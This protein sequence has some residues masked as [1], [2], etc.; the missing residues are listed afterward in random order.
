[1]R[2]SAST[3]ARRGRPPPCSTA[4]PSRRC[5]LGAAGCGDAERRGDRR[6]QAGRR[7]CRRA[8]R[9]A[10]PR[11]PSPVSSNGASATP[12]RSS[13]PARPY[14]PETLTGHLLAH[15]VATASSAGH[16]T[17]AGHARPSGDVGR[18]Q[19]RPAAR[20]RPGRRDRR[21]RPSSRNRSPRPATMPVSAGSAPAT[22]SPS[23]TSAGGRSTPPSSGSAPTA[24]SCSGAPRASTA[25]VASTSTR[26]CSPT[27][28]PPSTARCGR[29]TATTPTCVGRRWSCAPSASPPRR[30]CR[31]TP[32]RRSP[33]AS[34]A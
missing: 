33:F 19:A 22:P 16:D 7:R 29:W 9:A 18:V 27:S 17:V 12:P 21:R 14:G 25:S 5:K 13:S 20:G 8:R 6:R 15:V 32:R 26:P 28:T 4:T 24:P 1:M 23:T 31:P 2:D 34:R 3:S 10:T 30:R 11:Q